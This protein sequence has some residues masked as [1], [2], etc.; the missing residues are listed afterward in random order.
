MLNHSAE[1][2]CG[3]LWQRILSASSATNEMEDE[4]NQGDHE[5]QMDE[6]TGNMKG[7]PTTPKEQKNNSD[8]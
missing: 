3:K 1:R 7:K 2:V 5:Q 6:S 4:D 8:N